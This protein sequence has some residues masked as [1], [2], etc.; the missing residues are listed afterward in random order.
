MTATA[1]PISAAK[2]AGFWLRFAALVIEIVICFLINFL[3]V[4][5][6]DDLYVATLVY[7]LIVTVYFVYFNCS[8]WQGTVGKILLK[9][10]ITTLEGKRISLGRS[11]ARFVVLSLP[12]IPVY[13]FMF[14]FN[15]EEWNHK[16]DRFNEQTMPLEAMGHEAMVAYFAEN[17]EEAKQWQAQWHEVKSYLFWLSAMIG[18]FLLLHVAWAIPLWRRP[19]KRALHDIICGTQ[20]LQ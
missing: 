4:A 9:L 8:R 14:A 15:I 10:R 18:A 11:I 3:T 17:P 12:S 13:V 19:D 1:S 20:V 16:L 7:F 2:P 6:F 5:L